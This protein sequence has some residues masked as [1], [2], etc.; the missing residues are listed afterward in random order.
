M[1]I[2]QFT[3]SKMEIF[4]PPPL[5]F[6]LQPGA[7]VKW[8]KKEKSPYKIWTRVVCTIDTSKIYGDI[9]VRVNVLHL[10]AIEFSII[11][12]IYMTSHNRFYWD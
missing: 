11:A 8:R 5:N 10:T 2:F 3:Y 7:K 9:N 6:L 4:I 12:Y 1:R